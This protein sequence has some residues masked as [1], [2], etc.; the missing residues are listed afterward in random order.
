MSMVKIIVFH[1]NS[2]VQPQSSVCVCVCARHFTDDC[3]CNL[4]ELKVGFTKRLLL[5]D[6]SLSSLFGPAGSTGSQTVSMINNICL[7]FLSTLKIQNYGNECNISD[8]CCTLWTNHNGLGL[9]TN[10]SRVG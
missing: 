6:G 9:L 7:Y 8:T 2:V 10:Q 1:C 5:K 4:V 3:F